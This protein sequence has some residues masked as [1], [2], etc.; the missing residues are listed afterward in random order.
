MRHAVSI[1]AIILL[2]SACSSNQSS[3]QPSDVSQ[4]NFAGKNQNIQNAVEKIPSQESPVVP[5]DGRLRN[6]HIQMYVSVKIKQ[7][8]LRYEQSIAYIKTQETNTKATRAISDIEIEKLAIEHFDLNPELY[9]WSKK[10]INNTL[11]RS[12]MEDVSKPRRISS[13]EE[14]VV[15]HNFS[16]IEKFKDELRFAQ[17]YKLHPP[18]STKPKTTKV[19]QAFAEQQMA[20]FLKPSY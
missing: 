20:L 8:Q 9:F 5:M 3:N 6:E 7:E 12:A 13:F 2:L 18:T 1:A 15:V 11:K 17:Q 14:A 4:Q 16:M 19:K 10:I